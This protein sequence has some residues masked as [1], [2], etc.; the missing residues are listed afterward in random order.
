M[1]LCVYVC[2]LFPVDITSCA[3]RNGG[4]DQLCSLGAEGRVK[5]SCREGW[6]LATDQRTCLGNNKR[7][8]THTRAHTLALTYCTASL[9]RFFILSFSPSVDIDEC[10]MFNGGCEQ[11]CVNQAGSFNC[12]CKPGF[13]LRTDD[14]T[15]CQRESSL[16]S[17]NVETFSYS[18]P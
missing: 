13:E 17:A 18:Q 12:T 6:E 1:C 14:P 16:T 5:C 10:V 2:I 15:K 9:N 3:L 11:V 7:H 4:C 8:T